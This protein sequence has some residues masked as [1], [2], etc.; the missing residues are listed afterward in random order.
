MSRDEIVDIIAKHWSKKM[1]RDASRFFR[2]FSKDGPW[3][4]Y[5][6]QWEQWKP[7]RKDDVGYIGSRMNRERRSFTPEEV[8]RLSQTASE[9]PRDTALLQFYLQTGCRSSAAVELMVNDVWDAEGGRVVEEGVV[10]EKYHRMFHFRINDVLAEALTRWIKSAGV[11]L[12]VFPSPKNT[13]Q[14]WMREHGPRIWLRD[15]CR[16]AGID[17]S[18]VYVHGLRRT[19]C[20]MRSTMGHSKDELSKFLGHRLWST[21]RQYID[22]AALPPTV[23]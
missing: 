12:Y 11:T 15:L 19:A 4:G 8:H 13:Q 3:T 9:D 1:K 20:T 21:T 14:Q 7:I 23:H 6:P 17:G 16:R 5:I 18:H 10:L 22:P 2:Q